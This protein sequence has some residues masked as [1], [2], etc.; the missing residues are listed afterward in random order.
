MNGCGLY[1]QT[2]EELSHILVRFLRYQGAYRTD[3][4]VQLEGRPIEYGKGCPT[5]IAGWFRVE[6]IAKWWGSEECKRRYYR[7]KS[8]Y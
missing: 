4:E 5:D 6:D 1:A 7:Y 3:H 2:L 8:A